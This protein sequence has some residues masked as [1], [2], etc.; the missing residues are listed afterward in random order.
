MTA[1]RSEEGREQMIE[2]AIDGLLLQRKFAD[3]LRTIVGSDSWK[4]T[5]IPVPGTK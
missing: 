3:A 2:I 1:G 5:A 4:G